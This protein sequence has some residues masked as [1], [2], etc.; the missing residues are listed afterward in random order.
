LFLADSDGEEY[1]LKQ[2]PAHLHKGVTY[3]VRRILSFIK[4]LAGLCHEALHHRFVDWTKPDTTSL[5]FGT[6]TDLPRSK[7]QLVAENAR[8]ASTTDRPASTDETACLY[9]DR[10]NALGPAV[11]NSADLETGVVH[12]SA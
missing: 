9:Q 7:F 12:R 10:P 6:L 1:N 8:Y 4:R 2:S 5:L 3:T 11:K